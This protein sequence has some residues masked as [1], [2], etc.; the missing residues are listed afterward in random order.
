MPTSPAGINYHPD[1]APVGASRE[2]LE[3]FQTRVT[4]HNGSG[5]AIAQGDAL[6][7]HTNTTLGLGGGI[8]ESDN[9]TAAGDNAERFTGVAL[10]DIA[11][12]AQGPVCAGGLCYCSVDAGVAQWDPLTS[13]ATTA[14]H[15][16]AAA[17]ADADQL[18]AVALE[19]I[20]ATITGQALVRVVPIF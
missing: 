17:A 19:A 14:G 15:L 18:L 2:V 4:M 11:D 6:Y 8:E 9:E 16:A 10:E 20:D 5:A 12:G 3:Q 7:T 13:G 1:I